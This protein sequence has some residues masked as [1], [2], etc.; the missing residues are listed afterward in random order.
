MAND[1]RP[2]TNIFD[3]PAFAR[4]FPPTELDEPL[5]PRQGDGVRRW[6]ARARPQV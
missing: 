1:E 3:T 4:A 5:T 6:V 2:H